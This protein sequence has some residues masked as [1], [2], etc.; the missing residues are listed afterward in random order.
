[1]A[2][3][4]RH[5]ITSGRVV[6][7]LDCEGAIKRMT[8]P[9][10]PKAKAEHYDMIMECRKLLDQLPIEVEFK[11]IEGHQDSKGKRLDWW[12]RQNIRMDQR[13]KRFW[14]LH[15]HNPRHNHKLPNENIA[16]FFKDRKLHSLDKKQMHEFLTEK[17]M[18]QFWV[19]DKKDLKEEHWPMA[20]WTANK[21]AIK[22]QPKGMQRFICKFTSRHI[23]VGRMM[24][25][26]QHW[27]H[28]RCPLCGAEEE[29]T[30]HVLQCPDIRAQKTW[31]I[32]LG[33]LKIWMELQNT[34][35]A[36][37]RHILKHLRA[38][39]PGTIKFNCNLDERQLVALPRPCPPKTTLDGS[40]SC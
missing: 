4:L 5:K 28:S 37:Q 27:N 7:G 15:K 35:P 33:K 32:S 36:L 1:M 39:K 13:A 23:A 20:D 19:K 26:R 8:S 29:T 9:H 31:R 34:H 10:P 6:L 24:L 21:T 2:L 3:C 22:E 40:T 14:R 38:S 16:I 17:V 12:A 11:W 30:K 18:K 25:K